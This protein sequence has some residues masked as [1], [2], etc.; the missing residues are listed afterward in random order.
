[1]WIQKQLSKFT[2]NGNV[3]SDFLVGIPNMCCVEWNIGGS[4]LLNEVPED[5]LTM[6]ISLVLGGVKLT[7]KR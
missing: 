6:H 2:E 4:H 3:L 5:V 1:M 7:N